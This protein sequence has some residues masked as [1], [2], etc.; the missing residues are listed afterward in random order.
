MCAHQAPKGTSAVLGVCLAPV[1]G[2]LLILPLQP[3]GIT[4]RRRRNAHRTGEVSLRHDVSPKRSPNE[5]IRVFL[6]NCSNLLIAEPSWPSDGTMYFGLSNTENIEPEFCRVPWLAFHLS[7]ACAP[8]A[9]CIFLARMA[10]RGRSSTL[11]VSVFVH[12]RQPRIL[13]QGR[14]CPR[15]ALQVAAQASRVC[16]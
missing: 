8:E 13:V 3:D 16:R 6:Q 12:G 15:P 1:R 7:E 5:V 11:A 9:S 4:N 2:R 10:R 14:D